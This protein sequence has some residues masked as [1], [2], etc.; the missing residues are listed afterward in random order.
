MVH[1]LHHTQPG[2]RHSGDRLEQGVYYT[3]P[4][5]DKQNGHDKRHKNEHEGDN[6]H[7]LVHLQEG[8]GLHPPKQ[9][10]QDRQ[11]DDHDAI[12]QAVLPFQKTE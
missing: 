4:R 9:K 11:D 7:A 3:H 10:A 5:G 6:N 1:R 2:C 8:R 12:P